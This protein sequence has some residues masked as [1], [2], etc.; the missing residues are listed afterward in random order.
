MQATLPSTTFTDY[1]SVAASVAEQLAADAVN[2]DRSGELPT[3]EVEALKKSGLLLLP[4]PRQYGGAGATWP[5]VY[6][7]V[8]ALANAQGSVGQLYANHVSLVAAVEAIGR[9]G[10]AEHYYRLT[11]QHNLFWANAINGRD[12]RL[13]IAPAPEGGF[14]VNGVKSFGTGLAVADLSIIGAMPPEGDLPLVFVLPQDRPGWAYNHDWD[15]IG[16][17][18]TA[19][20]SYRFD[21]VVVYGDELIGPPPVPESAFPT[22]AFLVSQMGKVFTYL[23]I[24]EGA[25]KAARRYTVTES[26]PWLFSGVESASQDPYILH[27]YGELWAQLQAAIALS[28]QTAEQIQLGWQKKTALTF[29]ERGEIA[30]SLAAAKALAIAAGLAITNQIFDGMGAR[31]TASRHGFDRYWRDLRTFSLHDPV[32]YKFR[33]VGNY[34]LNGEYPVP[35]QYS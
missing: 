33:D 20:G 18:R 27:Q 24:A 31:A 35:S 16:Q 5:Q 3:A 15:N 10:Q 6:Q 19:S 17:R 32:A 4:I 26:R 34:V 25:L 12:S 1:L 7:A 8:Q 2:Q 21:N 11:A 30:V 13:K 22:L 29:E 14:R 9:P 28:D 23:G